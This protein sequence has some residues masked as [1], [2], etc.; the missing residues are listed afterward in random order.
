MPRAG[1]GTISLTT[2]KVSG[3]GPSEKKSIVRQ[4]DAAPA[5]VGQPSANLSA[6]VKIV[7]DTSRLL[8]AS[9]R[10]R[11]TDSTRHAATSSPTSLHA[12]TPIEMRKTV[13]AD[14]QPS[15]SP[16]THSLTMR[17]V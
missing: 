7:A 4:S 11:P 3:P 6:I 12:P 14:T 5:A 8:T 9:V 16:P 13:C 2:T 15:V 10:R 17:G 1:S